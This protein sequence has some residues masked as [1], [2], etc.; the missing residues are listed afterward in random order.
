MRLLLAAVICSALIGAVG[1]AQPS[2]PRPFDQPVLAASLFRAAWGYRHDRAWLESQLEWL[3][4]HHFDAIRALGVVGNPAAP[5]YW[6]GREID[7]RWP[8]YDEVIAGLTDLAYDRYGLKVQWTI[9][10]DAQD[11]I[12]RESD[13]AAL[14]ERFLKMSRGRERKIL[15]FEVANEFWKN[16]F[17]GAEGIRQLAA[18]SRKLHQ[19][20]TIPVA[21]SSHRDEL[22]SLY[23][24]GAVDFSTIHFDRGAPNA[25]WAPLTEPWTI[26]RRAGR[27]ASC[28]MPEQASNNEP[29]GP[30]AAA[31]APM[32][33]LQIVMSAVNTYLSQIPL[34]V[35][36]SGPGIRDDESAPNGLRPARF[37][38]LSDAAQVFDG[39]AAVQRYIPR[40]VLTWRPLAPTDEEFPFTIKGNAGVTLA[41]EQRGRVLIAVSGIRDAMELVARAGIQ[42]RRI[43]PLTGE[44]A[45]EQSLKTG[46]SV[47]FGSEAVL[48]DGNVQWPRAQP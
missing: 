29:A 41:V 2:P 38:Q 16:G 28:T 15:A 23:S 18:Y 3:R 11:N 13:R 8:D 25:G 43:D 35:F 14:V 7:W 6:D 22:C 10:A 36:H 5:D 12:P 48:L 39:L 40:D 42:L 44:T 30:G 24:S 31:S 20:T 1:S 19:A 33:P 34:Y 9:F 27:F 26:A 47:R 32:M 46:D 17:D 4:A 21:A 45:E 37:E